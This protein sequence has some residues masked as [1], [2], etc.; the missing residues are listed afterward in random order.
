MTGDAQEAL[1]LRHLDGETTQLEVAQVTKLLADDA[2]IRTRFFAC[3]TTITEL[4]E[5]LDMVKPEP[6][7]RNAAK[8]QAP[9]M[10]VP[11]TPVPT[12]APKASEGRVGGSI[13]LRHIYFN[14][15]LGGAGGLVGW[16]LYAL[17]N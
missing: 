14:A 10:P 3:A 17:L 4:Q 16:L 1:I 2:E 8:G 9:A 15:I 13:D 6:E 5:I 7:Q 12:P 11:K